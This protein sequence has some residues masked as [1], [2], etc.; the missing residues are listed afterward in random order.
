LYEAPRPYIYLPE[1]QL[2]QS[3]MMLLVSANSASDLQV[4]AENARHE[5]AQVD[6][7][8]PVSGVTLAEAN[9]S[10]AYWSPRPVAGL[11]SALGLLALLLAT[12]GLYSVMTYTTGQ[13]T[14]HIGIP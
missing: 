4:I 10:F 6:A 14:P 8:L 5:I 9:M 12:M 7:R 1:Y 3:S 2:Y 13:R 11:A